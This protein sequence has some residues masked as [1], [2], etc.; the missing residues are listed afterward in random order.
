MYTIFSTT[1]KTMSFIKDDAMYEVFVGCIRENA[2]KESLHPTCCLTD[3][4]I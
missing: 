1:P 3:I 2:A 4:Y